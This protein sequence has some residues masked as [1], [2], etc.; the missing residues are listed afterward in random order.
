M[1]IAD[2][3]HL[4]E[5]AQGAAMEKAAAFLAEC[6][7]N[8]PADGRMELDGD[9][10]YAMVQSYHTRPG[11]EN[12]RFEAHRRYTDV[13]FVLAGF[14]LCGWAP[15]ARLSILTPYD[16]ARD[17]LFGR[18]DAADSVLLPFPAGRALVFHPWDAHAPCLAAAEPAPV[19]K[20]VVKVAV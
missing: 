10:L 12:P 1:T 20:I 14:E 8:P 13:Q 7:R 18:V 4:P 17:V 3:D 15:L 2:L 6:V 19:R 16:E 9:R 5:S 11:R